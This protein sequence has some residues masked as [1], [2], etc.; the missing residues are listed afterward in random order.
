ML[1]SDLTGFGF[2]AGLEGHILAISPFR[3]NSY[4]SLIICRSGEFLAL[5]ERRNFLER[6]DGGEKFLGFDGGNCM[7]CEFAVGGFMNIAIYCLSCV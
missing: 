5:A 1:G 2:G 3:R 4:M 7:V 6:V